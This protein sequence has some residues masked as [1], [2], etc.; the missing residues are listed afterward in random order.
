MLVS[1]CRLFFHVKFRT[2]H[3]AFGLY[4]ESALEIFAVLQKCMN[5]SR[6]V[7]GANGKHGHRDSRVLSLTLNSTPESISQGMPLEKLAAPQS[8]AIEQGNSWTPGEDEDRL[9]KM[10]HLWQ[11]K[12]V[13][14]IRKI[15]KIQ[16]SL[17][18]R[19]RAKEKADM[20]T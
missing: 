13:K 19:R 4:G 14:K 2:P 6:E 9:K 3:L 8:L 20:S 7:A 15:Q 17:S 1:D 10:L 12:F 18:G 16:F 11:K 5:S